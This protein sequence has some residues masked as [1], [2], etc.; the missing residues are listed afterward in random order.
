MIESLLDEEETDLS[1]FRAKVDLARS[2]FD[3]QLAF[4]GTLLEVNNKI[5]QSSHL[6]RHAT[7]CRDELPL[8]VNRNLRKVVYTKL[9]KYSAEIDDFC[10]RLT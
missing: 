8:N 7:L 1:Y 3:K 10:S 5:Q 6:G 4:N 9:E 2:L